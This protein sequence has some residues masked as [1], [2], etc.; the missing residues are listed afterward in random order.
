MKFN[1][2]FYRTRNG[3]LAEIYAEKYGYYFGAIQWQANDN[4]TWK[5]MQWWAVDMHEGM[6]HGLELSPDLDLI[7]S[8][9]SSIAVMGKV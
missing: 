6:A 4:R 9:P 2:S 8:T 7:P 1:K 5:A 3:L